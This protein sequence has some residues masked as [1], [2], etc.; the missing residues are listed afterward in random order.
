MNT[1]FFKTRFKTLQI[2]WVG[3]VRGRYV[4]MIQRLHQSTMLQDSRVFF[5]VTYGRIIIRR[6]YTTRDLIMFFILAM[7]L[8]AGIKA[9]AAE[10][11]TIGFED[12]TL[13]P[14]ATLYDLNALEQRFIDEGTAISRN[15]AAQV[16][17]C[18]Q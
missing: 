14:A 15:S 2:R 6:Q 17:A 10:T 1:D 4:R 18:T 16:R 8:G 5:T 12:Y 7:M 11:V 9:V 3:Y 13:A